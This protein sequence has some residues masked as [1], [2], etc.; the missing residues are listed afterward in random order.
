ML[1]RMNVPPPVA[2]AAL[3]AATVIITRGNWG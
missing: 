3:A 2:F 1:E